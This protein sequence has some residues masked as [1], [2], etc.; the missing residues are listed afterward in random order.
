MDEALSGSERLGTK[1]EMVGSAT[2]GA[3]SDD[4]RETLGIEAE[5]VGNAIDGADSVEKML[6]SRTLEIDDR[7]ETVGSASDGIETE[8]STGK[9]SENEL[10]RMDTSES[11]NVFGSVGS[12]RDETDRDK[13]VG[14][15]NDNGMLGIALGNPEP[16][17]VG[18][19]T[20][21]RVMGGL[22]KSDGSNETVKSDGRASS[23]VRGKL[24]GSEMLRV[25][26]ATEGSPLGKLDSSEQISDRGPASMDDAIGSLA[27]RPASSEVTSHGRPATI[28]DK[29]LGIGARAVVNGRFVDC[30]RIGI[31][32]GKAVG[33]ADSKEQMFPVEPASME[34]MTASL[35][36]RPRLVRRPLTSHGRAASTEERELGIGSSAVVKAGPLDSGT[37]RVG[38]AA[39]GRPDN[40]GQM[41]WV[42]PARIEETTGLPPPRPRADSNAATSHSRPASTEESALGSGTRPLVSGNSVGRISP[43]SEVKPGTRFV[44]GLVVGDPGAPTQFRPSSP[45]SLVVGVAIMGGKSEVNPGTRLVRS[46][47]GS[48]VVSGRLAGSEGRLNDKDGI[49][50]VGK[51]VGIVSPLGIDTSIL[52]VESSTGIGESPPTI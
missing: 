28:D 13:P 42:G 4:E 35:L 2:V 36:E 16:V 31:D 26:G 9:L 51:P 39:A 17:T 29:A 11:D 52:L 49:A 37:L 23:V 48:A 8:G 46:L 18:K 3:D 43:I 20:L 27:D 7:P 41:L 12:A 30:P 34:D 10:L 1:A 44:S 25:G 19:A 14:R 24:D 45:Q 22:L 38:I 40:R 32:E 33:K 15:L 47:I 6:G 5:I 50:I 21:G